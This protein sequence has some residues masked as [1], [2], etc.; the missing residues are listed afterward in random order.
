[1]T[2]NCVSARLVFLLNCNLEEVNDAAPC[3]TCKLTHQLSDVHLIIPF[4][5]STLEN[6]VRAQSLVHNSFR[7]FKLQHVK[8]NLIIVEI[9]C[10]NYVQLALD[11]QFVF[12]KALRID[13]DIFKEIFSLV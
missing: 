12:Q 6:K 8:V 9:C 4:S 10:N 5:S 1:M 2:H 13:F 7:N 11:I 3:S